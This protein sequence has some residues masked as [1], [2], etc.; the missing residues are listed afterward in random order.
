MAQGGE[1]EIEMV[2][3]HIR[4]GKKQIAHQREIV[5]RLPPSSDVAEAARHLLKLFE[6]TQELHL[7]HL[8]RL[9]R[10]ERNPGV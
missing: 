7:E 2:Q 9:L 3:R 5:T 6:E 4:M 1:T 8:D 10:Q